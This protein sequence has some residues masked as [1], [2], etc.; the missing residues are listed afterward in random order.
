MVQEQDEG[1]STAINHHFVKQAL[2]PL[3][4]LLLEQLFKQED[5]QDKDDTVWNVSM[6]A[7]ACLGLIAATVGDDVVPDVVQF[8]Q[9]WPVTSFCCMLSCVYMS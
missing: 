4:Q 2:R 7:G 6:T 8:V 1:D 3:L 5:D 9:V